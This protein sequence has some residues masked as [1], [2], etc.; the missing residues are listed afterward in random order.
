M[1]KVAQKLNYMLDVATGNK[2]R[3]EALIDFVKSTSW[4]GGDVDRFLAKMQRVGHPTGDDLLRWYAANNKMELEI[5]GEVI[6]FPQ[7]LITGDVQGKFE[8]VFV[9]F[10]ENTDYNRKPFQYTAGYEGVCSELEERRKSKFPGVFNGKNLRLLNLEIVGEGDRSRIKT[11]HQP[12]FYFSSLGTHYSLDE[13]LTNGAITLRDRVHSEG[14]LQSL[15]T[16]V[17][18]NPMGIN[19]LVI[20]E[21]NLAIIQHRGEKMAIRP[22]EACSSAS[23]T[24]DV[25]DN[26]GRY[27][28]LLMA[29]YREIHE[30]I[31]LEVD[32]FGDVYFLGAVREFL[33]G[34]LPDFFFAAK[35]DIGQDEIIKRARDSNINVDK[36]EWENIQALMMPQNKSNSFEDYIAGYVDALSKLGQ[37]PSLPLLTNIALLAN[38]QSK[39]PDVF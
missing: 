11:T 5:A 26:F 22:L 3:L 21:K 32:E 7:E 18:A 39:N 29:V 1:K 19:L 6:T 34:G 10:S 31:A 25:R 17:M 33:R 16:S 37:P 14:K 13:P 30:E 24:V 15:P 27:H 28:P 8:D 35:A 23:G 9:E 2:E 4:Y 38:F 20:L 12:V 36:D